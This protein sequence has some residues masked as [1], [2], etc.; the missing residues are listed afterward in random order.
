[1]IQPEEIRSAQF[2]DTYYPLMDGVIQTV[3]NYAEIM[4]RDSYACVIT[5]KP[6]KKNYDDSL[7]SYD[8]F[9]TRSLR[10]PFA[11]YSIP[12][13]KFDPALGKFIDSRAIDIFHVHSPFY[14]G[15]YASMYAKRLGIP[16]VSTFHSKY[17]D[18]AIHLTGS[19]AVA[20]IVVRK[21][22]R[23]Y[24][25]V[26]SVW[27][28][29]PGTADTLRS[30]GYAGNIFVMDNGT[31]FK[32]PDHPEELRRRAA[33]EYSIPQDKKVIL[34]VGHQIWHKNIKL[35]LDTFK[36][37]DE[38]AD[39]YR[40]LIVGDGYDQEE[41][42]R[43]AEELRF[44]HGHVRFLGRIMDREILKGIYL[45]ADLL[46]FPSVYDNSPLVVREAASLGLPSL[47]TEGSN[48]A[49]VV[50]KNETGFTATENK[51]AMYREVLRIF[52]TEG[53]LERVSEGA[54]REVAKSWEEIVPR[55]REKYAEILEEY[56]FKTNQ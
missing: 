49:E 29:S 24:N 9:R 19:K 44:K 35:I 47:L 17:Y 48:A 56:R 51:V 1:M 37:L 15:S 7:L 10:V 53:L 54:R 31:T 36:M 26:D 39:D 14:E 30:Y 45:N 52:S 18:D 20:R 5:P 50:R 25:S 13:P 16:C 40:L 42:A 22:V 55:V 38:K 41:I 27:A 43:Y 4:N 33:A 3:H 21:I 46:F 34:F 2:L 23:F 11:E 28:C 8:V 6:L 32:M 12:T